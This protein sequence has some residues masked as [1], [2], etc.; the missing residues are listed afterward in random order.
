MTF[1][2]QPFAAERKL[3]FLALE[4]LRQQTCHPILPLQVA[5]DCSMLPVALSM[6]GAM[7][8]DQ[9]LD[10]SSWMTVHETLQEKYIKLKEMRPEKMTPQ[11][12]SIF[13]TIDASVE[14]LPRTVREQLHLMVVLASGVTA[15]SEMLANLWDVVRSYHYLSVWCVGLYTSPL[16]LFSVLVGVLPLLTLLRASLS[17]RR[18][19]NKLGESSKPGDGV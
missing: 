4:K 14:N 12:K 17:Y 19:V 7:A 2:E 15:S 5:D 10:A 13:S 3:H 8:K 11:A 1:L 16:G 6:A 18:T 9:P